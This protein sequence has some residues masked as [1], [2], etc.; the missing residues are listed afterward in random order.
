MRIKMEINL[1]LLEKQRAHPV[2]VQGEVELPDVPREVPEVDALS[3]VTSDLVAEWEEDVCHL[4]GDLRAVVTYQCSRCLEPFDAQLVAPFE[5]AF[6]ENAAKADGEDIHH[7][8][9]GTVLL[10]PYIEQAVHLALDNRPLCDEACKGLCPVCGR[11]RN[12]EPC[13]CDTRR[14]D[15]RLEALRDLLSSPHSE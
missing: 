15:P 1:K 7:S 4:H 8:S 13:Q 3:P 11:N 2:H 6:T 5:E 14:I 12:V 9:D 10:D